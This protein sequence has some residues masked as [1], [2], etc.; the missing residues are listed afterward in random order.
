MLTDARDFD[1]TLVTDTNTQR[2]MFGFGPSNIGRVA[3]SE[4]N[5]FV[6]TQLLV[7][8]NDTVSAPGYSWLGDTSTGMY[9]ISNN[10]IGLACA[11][12][13]ILTVTS[14]GIG[15]KSSNP[16]C[17]V[18]IID[19]GGLAEVRVER[20][21]PDTNNNL[22]AYLT[23]YKSRGT[24]A[25]PT[26]LAS[27]DMIGS[28][29][30]FGHDGTSFK[31][32]SEIRTHAENNSTNNS[33]GSRIVL[34]TRDITNSA[35]LT[36]RMIIRSTKIDVMNDLVVNSSLGVGTSSLNTAR[37]CISTAG[38]NLLHLENSVGGNGTACTNIVFSTWTGGSNAVFGV[39]D[40]NFSAHFRFL[41]R[42]PG[43]GTNGLTERMRIT[44]TGNV[45]IGT[46]TPSSA[47]HVIGVINASSKLQQG[48]NDLSTFF[49]PLNHTHSA[50]AISGTLSR[51]LLPS[52][53]T[54]LAG[55]VV[56]NDSVTSVSTSQAATANAVNKVKLRL[57]NYLDRSGVEAYMSASQIRVWTNQMISF[58]S[59]TDYTY[60]QPNANGRLNVYDGANTNI[61]WMGKFDCGS[62]KYFYANGGI[63]VPMWNTGGIK[64]GGGI[65]HIYYED[66]GYNIGSGWY[67]KYLP[68]D[69]LI[70][71][72]SLDGNYYAKSDV[73]DKTNIIAVENAID[74]ILNID[75]VYF[76]WKNMPKQQN[77]GCIAQNVEQH[78]PELVTETPDGKMVNY[79]GLIPVL[80]QAFKEL[81]AL[82]K[83]LIQT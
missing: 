68:T 51:D 36:D 66:Y 25:A 8:S 31:M 29:A 64:W 41:T 1:V 83:P 47:L 55:A 3:L 16:A 23:C 69:K 6:N 53:T 42:D 27:N 2:V 80:I 54:S 21:L 12:N 43:A 20:A 38:S 59:S 40:D 45:G 24:N 50:D 7:S 65:G 5:V 56:L 78:I 37:C 34:A 11:G 10:Q 63:E 44:N 17:P 33:I 73:K 30:S 60:I 72:I 32:V 14:L 15:V 82:V 74:K 79:T 48:G 61:F 39:L 67:F 76:E 75:G 35:V 62:T 4:S 22:P 28:V 49:A 46:T 26:A 71:H 13:S 77:I 52:A 18:H 70:A 58:N 81:H 57:D 9:H 19:N